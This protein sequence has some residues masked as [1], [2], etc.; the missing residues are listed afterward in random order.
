ME[1][2]GFHVQSETVEEGDGGVHEE[3][4]VLKHAENTEVAGE[5][6]REPELAMPF[7]GAPFEAEA[8][9]QSGIQM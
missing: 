9:G 1:V 5:A 4:A 2:P 8:H 3:T 7:E 6:E